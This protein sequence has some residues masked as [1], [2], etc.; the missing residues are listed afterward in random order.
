M[1]GSTAFREERLDDGGA[2][3]GEDA[4]GDFYLMVEARVGEDFEAGTNCPAFG[5]IRA[6]NET[7]EPRLDDGACAHGARLDGDVK[8][9]VGEAVVAKNTCS[10]AKNNDFGVSGG[11]AI[12]DG[13]VARTGEN[14]AVMD[15]HGADG[16]FAGC[17]GSVRFNQ[18]FPHELDVSFHLRRENNTRKQWK[19]I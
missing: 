4:S 13:A 10:F 9:G 3:N 2:L 1:R 14:F 19:R 16:D 7:R 17:S 8:R 15:E 12:A 18:R 6:V 11:V 5:I